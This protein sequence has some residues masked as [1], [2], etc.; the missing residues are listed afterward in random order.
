[1]HTVTCPGHS[2]RKAHRR[3][4][5]LANGDPEPRGWLDL[6]ALGLFVLGVIAL[7]AFVSGHIE[8]TIR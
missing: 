8:M 1:M 4:L 3:A 2:E 5:A 7:V 6:V